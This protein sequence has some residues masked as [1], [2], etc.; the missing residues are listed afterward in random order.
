MEQRVSTLFLD[1]GNV[2]LTNG[3]DHTMRGRAAE[4]FHFDRAEME[5]RHHLTFGTYEEGKLS[6]DEY[7]DRILFYEPRPFTKG[8]FVDFMFKQSQPFPD[9]I[10]LIRGLKTKYGLK[11]AIVSNEG[12]ELAVYRIRKFNLGAFVDFFIFSSFVHFRKPDIDIYRVALDIAQVQP[13]QIV[14]IEDREMFVD[15]AK[16]LGILAIKQRDCRTT[17]AELAALGLVLDE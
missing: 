16:S 1:V 7:L 8:D 5:E 4:T 3:W 10:D 9:M 17:R 13:G 12:R 11:V 14:Y 2:L 15:I 6:L